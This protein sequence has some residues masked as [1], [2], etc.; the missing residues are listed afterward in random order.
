MQATSTDQDKWTASGVHGR[1]AED[2][3]VASEGKGFR[4][5]EVALA[6]LL[7]LSRASS[8]QIALHAQLSEAMFACKMPLIAPI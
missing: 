8:P 5:V 4:Y 6:M 7:L 1:L 2:E 3:K